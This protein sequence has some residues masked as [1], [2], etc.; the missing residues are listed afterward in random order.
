[1]EHPA[2]CLMLGR[3]IGQHS[4]QLSLVRAWR[5]TAGLDGQLGEAFDPLGARQV[6]E[7]SDAI[8]K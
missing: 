1:M 3:P 8:G 6:R 5:K 7:D 2:V 4:H